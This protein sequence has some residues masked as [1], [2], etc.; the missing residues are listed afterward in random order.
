MK[1]ANEI[2]SLSE[3]MA[4]DQKNKI[5]GNVLKKLKIKSSDIAKN[6]DKIADFIAD[7]AGYNDK[8][9]KELIDWVH[10]MAD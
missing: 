4:P 1:L 10:D 7:S 6:I 8:E 9:K 3:K 5:I 2:L